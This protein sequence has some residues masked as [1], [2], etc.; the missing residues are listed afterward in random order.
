MVG[1]DALYLELKHGKIPN[2]E[3]AEYYQLEKY[4]GST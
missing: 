4:K 3:W 1:M 2:P